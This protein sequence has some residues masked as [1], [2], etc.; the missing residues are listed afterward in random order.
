MK[1]TKKKTSSKVA[2]AY[3][4]LPFSVTVG[5]FSLQIARVERQYIGHA[6]RLSICDF[7]N[8]EIRLDNT[9]QGVELLRHF[10]RRLVQTIHYVH[11]VDDMSSEESV[12]HSLACGLVQFIRDNQEA[13]IW[14][15]EGLSHLKPWAKF[16]LNAAD[17]ESAPAAMAPRRVNIGDIGFDVVMRDAAWENRNNVWG[18]CD[19]GEQTISLAERLRGPYLAVVAIHEFIHAMNDSKG[20]DDKS[21]LKQVTTGQADALLEFV[22]DNPKAWR[23]FMDLASPRKMLELEP[24]ELPLRFVSGQ[25]RRVAAKRTR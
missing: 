18:M 2:L 25:H 14:M 7:N 6:S 13:W 9:L 4:K 3:Q 8:Q 15:N 16:H 19:F 1:S 11:G 20:I 5:P 10:L 12:T 22:R 24:P 23:W 21:T 17:H